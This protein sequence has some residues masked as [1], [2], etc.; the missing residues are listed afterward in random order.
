MFISCKYKNKLGDGDLLECFA[1]V[2]LYWHADDSDASSADLKRI[3]YLSVI[4]WKL[5]KLVTN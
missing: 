5:R 1:V 4:N 2:A 3:F